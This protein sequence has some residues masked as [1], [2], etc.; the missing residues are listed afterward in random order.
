MRLL[1]G[2]GAIFRAGCCAI[3][4]PEKALLHQSVF[5]PIKFVDPTL[6][7]LLLGALCFGGWKMISRSC[8]AS[9]F[10]FVLFFNLVC[11]K[12]WPSVLER[13]QAF[14]CFSVG[15]WGIWGGSQLTGTMH[16]RCNK[17]MWHHMC[18]KY[19]ESV[20]T[21]FFFPSTYVRLDCKSPASTFNPFVMLLSQ[22]PN[23]KVLNPAFQHEGH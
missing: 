15:L 22:P 3:N 8:V 16:I 7:L 4:A 13:S 11:P 5:D 9:F 20:Y 17:A 6:R 10:C 19:T 21:F 2:W 1:R 18:R 23:A 14:N 12:W